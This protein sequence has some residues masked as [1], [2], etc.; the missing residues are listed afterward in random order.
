[1]FTCSIENGQPD[2]NSEESRAFEI[3]PIGEIH[4]L[5]NFFREIYKIKRKES[6]RI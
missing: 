3:K 6:L 2:G 4:I 5:F 1:M